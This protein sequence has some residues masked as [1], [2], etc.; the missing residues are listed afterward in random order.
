MIS[1]L[2]LQDM[3]LQSNSSSTHYNED[4]SIKALPFKIPRPPTFESVA[5]ERAFRKQRLALAFRIFAKM[6]YEEGVAGHITCRDPEFPSKFW[7]N[8]FGV[9]FSQI[10]ASDLILVNH[11]GQIEQGH[12][13][14]NAAAFAIHSGIHMAREDVV[15]ACH[16]HSMWGKSFST[17]GRTI[18]PITQDHCAFYNRHVLFN[19][20]NG[21]VDDTSEGKQ[22]AQSLG[23]TN[24]AAILQ[25]HGLLT[26]GKSIEEAVWWFISLDRCCQS[27]MIAESTGCKPIVLGH[28]VAEKTRDLV[29]NS[30]A[31]WFSGQPL[32]SVAEKEFPEAL[33]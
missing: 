22:I 26:V 16:S 3:S 24:H 1:D 33:L 9:A 17:L 29:G 21:V 27:T 19:Q 2:K 6:G 30:M 13:L 14:L 25:N 11:N 7:V 5:E 10:K 32:F 18:E 31:G 4:G 20:F 23:S 12:G 15:A 28:E 8:P